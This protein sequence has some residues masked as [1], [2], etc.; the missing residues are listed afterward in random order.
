MSFT[1]YWIIDSNFKTKY[2]NVVDYEEFDESSDEDLD[3]FVP[4]TIGT[5]IDEIEDDRS[6][7]VG[8][9]QSEFFF[10]FI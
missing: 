10:T 5:N 6:K 8:W 7:V 1:R 9:C 2:E 4:Q 3:G